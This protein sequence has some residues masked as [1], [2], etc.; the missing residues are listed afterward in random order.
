[1]MSL[2]EVIPALIILFGM[3]ALVFTIYQLSGQQAGR[4]EVQK[5]AIARGFATYDKQGKFIWREYNQ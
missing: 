5:E 4:I 3:I 2:D 1:M